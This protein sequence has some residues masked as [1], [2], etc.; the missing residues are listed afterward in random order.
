[1]RFKTTLVAFVALLLPLA[2][3]AS[4]EGGSLGNLISVAPGS[5]LWTILTFLLLLIVLWRFAWGPIVKG[6]E[7]REDKIYGAIEKAQ[8]NREEAEKLLEE[9]QEK[10]KQASNEIADRL[11]KADKQALTTVE[12]AKLEAQQSA[13]KML[14]RAKAEIERQRD[15]VVAELKAQVVDL[16][17][18]IA[19]AAIG[20]SFDKPQ[21]LEIIRKRLE[22]AEK[23]S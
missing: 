12:Q 4:E 18:Q 2:V 9:Y 20:E 8:Q 14:E 11:A 1:M 6:L 3:F 19:S 21:H 15:K 22:Q 10:L 16:A 7:A 5:M 17:A 13:E 23:N